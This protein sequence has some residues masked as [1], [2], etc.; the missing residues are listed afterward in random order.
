MSDSKIT[1]NDSY[2]FANTLIDMVGF[3]AGNWIVHEGIKSSPSPDM[4]KTII[5]GGSDLYVRNSGPWFSIP[6]IP[7]TG[8]FVQNGQIAGISFVVAALV[9]LFKGKKA[10]K[11]IIDNLVLNAVGI[12][13]NEVIDRVIYTKLV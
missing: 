3:Y 4:I 8:N 9:D 10:G 5:F 6:V 13:T 2:K 1:V 7:T 12:A 11:A